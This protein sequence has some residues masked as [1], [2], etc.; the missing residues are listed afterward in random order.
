MADVAAD[1]GCAEAAERV[2]GE[3]S[4]A[5]E[6]ELAGTLE[7]A[8]ERA[9]QVAR[10]GDVVLLSPACSSYDQFENYERRGDAFR[11]LARGRSNGA[12]R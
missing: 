3:L 6:V 5:V 4:G 10:P 7:R 12:G 8:V 2:S 11:D 1:S 9:R